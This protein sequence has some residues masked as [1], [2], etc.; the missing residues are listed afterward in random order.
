MHKISVA[1]V[2]AC[3]LALVS[4]VSQAGERLP[5][6]DGLACTDPDSCFEGDC[7]GSPVVCEDDG[8]ACTEDKCDEARG[9]CVHD[10][11]VCDD[12]NPCTTDT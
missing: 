8:N 10:P 7:T 5:C 3:A 2:F 9:G 1:I 6:D 12:L 11:I 4:G